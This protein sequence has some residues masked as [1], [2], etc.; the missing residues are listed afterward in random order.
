[1]VQ[2]E[3]S[4]DLLDILLRLLVAGVLGAFIGY[5]R[6]VHGRAAGLRTNILVCVGAALFMI[7]SEL[8][9]KRSLAA[10]GIHVPGI[11]PGRIAA[12]VV[13]GIGFLGAGVILKEG[14]TVRGLTTAACMWLVAGIG[15]A[16]GSGFFEIA[17][18]ATAIGIFCLVVLQRAERWYKKD[19]YRTLVIQTPNSTEI[20]H[21][22]EKVK[23]KNV[24]ILHCDY[25][26]DYVNDLLTVKLSMRLFHKGFT[27]R[28]SHT[29]IKELEGAG[30]SLRS[31]NWSH[32]LT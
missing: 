29:I 5:E 3:F 8:V 10:F 19:S 24:A 20:S 4:I 18:F 17:V 14:F 31:I 12:Q 22:L 9:A 6:D 11:D 25:E 7:I 32:S 26:R 28:F 13:T 30:L 27:D 2:T 23:K 15:M 16:A 21:I 1:M